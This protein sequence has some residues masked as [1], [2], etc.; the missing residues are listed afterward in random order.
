MRL[1]DAIPPTH[2]A[3]FRADF[4]ARIRADRVFKT[5]AFAIIA[6][7]TQG[8]ELADLGTW[9]FWIK[10]AAVLFVSYVLV[11][12]FER[13]QIARIHRDYRDDDES[14]RPRE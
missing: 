3:A 14:D 12:I 7:V 13:W 2:R 9:W 5:G 6:M 8:H 1:R 11:R 10:S 4:E